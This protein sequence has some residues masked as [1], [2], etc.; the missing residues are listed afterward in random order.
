M[1]FYHLGG[2]VVVLGTILQRK[3]ALFNSKDVAKAP[4]GKASAFAFK[5]QER[6]KTQLSGMQT[7]VSTWQFGEEPQSSSSQLR[8]A[9]SVADLAALTSV[10]DSRNLS[11]TSERTDFRVKHYLIV[12]SSA[13]HTF[14][15]L[16]FPATAPQ[17]GHSVAQKADPLCHSESAA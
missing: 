5:L 15:L 11:T 1:K 8:H 10:S 9:S 13:S 7:T 2:M 3:N 14:C 4:S 6:T 17:G 12:P 16:R